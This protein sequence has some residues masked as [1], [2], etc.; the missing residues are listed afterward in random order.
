MV[1]KKP[2]NINDEELS[3]GMSRIEQPLSLPTAMSY[4]LQKIRVAEM[5]SS[6]F[7][8]RQW[9]KPRCCHGHRY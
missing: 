4:S 1:V 5:Y 8:A 9:S 7:G 2:L 3:D 6:H